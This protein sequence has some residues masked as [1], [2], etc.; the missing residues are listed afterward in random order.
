MALSGFNHTVT[1][2][3]FRE[4]NQRP[5]NTPEAAYIRAT[6]TYNFSTQT[7]SGQTCRVL[8]VNTSISVS[9]ASTWVLRGHKTPVLLRAEPL[10]L[11]KMV[12]DSFFKF[13][14]IQIC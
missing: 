9:S 10:R 8:R 7:T 11:L 14:Y 13:G 4:V 6:Y 12:I 2:N 3:E 1:W 5:P